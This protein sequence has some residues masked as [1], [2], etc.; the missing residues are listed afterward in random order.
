MLRA[1]ERHIYKYPLHNLMSYGSQVV[2]TREGARVV[3]VGHQDHVPTIWLEISLNEPEERRLFV[4]YGTGQTVD[5]NDIPVGSYIDGD[6][7]WHI[8]ESNP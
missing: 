7:V 3:L 4:I 8:Y 2:E 1:N 6:F 5:D